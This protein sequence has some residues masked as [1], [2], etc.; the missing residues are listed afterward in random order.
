MKTI[1]L[2]MTLITG[3]LM[4]S[5]RQNIEDLKEELKSLTM[6]VEEEK[7]SEEEIENILKEFEEIMDGALVLDDTEQL[8]DSTSALNGMMDNL[9]DAIEDNNDVIEDKVQEGIDALNESF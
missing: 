2:A 8:R 6:P 1:I 9:K 3:L 7:A 4:V 5:C